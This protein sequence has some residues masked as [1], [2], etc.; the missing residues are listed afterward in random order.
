VPSGDRHA[1]SD[2]GS[3]P[4]HVRLQGKLI[5]EDAA[6][7]EVVANHLPDHIQLTLAEAGC[8]SFAVERTDDPLVWSV[9]EC[10]DGWPA[11][12]AH[13]LRTRASEWWEATKDIPREYAV[14]G[15]K[16]ES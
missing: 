16:R 1:R 14:S 9:S 8:L 12:D 2:G 4:S 15:P 10:F 5:C 7:A 6:Q 3:S 11:F 13:Q